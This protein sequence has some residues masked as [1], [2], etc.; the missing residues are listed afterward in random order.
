MKAIEIYASHRELL[1]K[2]LKDFVSS[3][4][5]N[6]PS[7]EA[8]ASKIDHMCN[9]IGS[10]ASVMPMLAAILR[11]KKRIK[12][13][14][15]P[16]RNAVGHF[17]WDDR[18]YVISNEGL[19]HIR[20]FY[21]SGSQMEP[22][23]EP[24][25]EYHKQAADFLNAHNSFMTV[26]HLRKGSYFNDDDQ[27]RDVY[28]IKLS[29][30]RHNYTFTFGQS[31]VSTEKGIQPSAYDVLACLQKYDPGTFEDFCSEYDY[32][33][34]SK[35]AEATYKAVVE[36]WVNVEKLYGDVIEELHEIN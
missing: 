35:K 21:F 29:R 17:R 2:E 10:P 6:D 14:D 8:L 30:G 34:D 18:V 20:N 26:K 13:P 16:D 36:E 5:G 27:V 23:F 33:T 11:G 7:I 9:G 4:T 12:F 1:A 28:E 32:D 3:F 15:Y 22:Y 25:N 24:S 19:H 31:V